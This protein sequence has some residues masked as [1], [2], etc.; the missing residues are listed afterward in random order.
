MT[1]ASATYSASVGDSVTHFSVL[2]NNDTQ[3]PPHITSPPE[4]DLLSAATLA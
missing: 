4:T 3:A 2:E 1:S